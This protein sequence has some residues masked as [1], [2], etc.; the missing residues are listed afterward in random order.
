MKLY[1]VIEGTGSATAI[2]GWIIH[3]I[4]NRRDL[5]EQYRNTAPEH[6]EWTDIEEHDL[7]ELCTT[8]DLPEL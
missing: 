2:D 8:D 1:V 5:A 7:F 3:G 4:F 6:P